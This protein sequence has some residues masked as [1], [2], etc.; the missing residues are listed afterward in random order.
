M[1][2]TI[3]WRTLWLSGLLLISAC[4]GG[5]DMLA[6]GG[7]TGSGMVNEGSISGF[8]S[9][10]VNDTR[11]ATEQ[12]EIRLNGEAGWSEQLKL[13]MHVIVEAT[14]DDN[15]AQRIIYRDLL[16]GPLEFIGPAS[17]RL[18]GH[19]VQITPDT[20]LHGVQQLSELQVGDTVRIS[21]PAASPDALF[22]TLLE[23]VPAG[24]VRIVGTVA[25]LD[26]ANHTFFIAGRRIDYSAVLTLAA[27]LYVGLPVEVVGLFGEG[28]LNARHIQSRRPE[29]LSEGKLA[30]IYGSVTRFDGPQDF[31]VQ[32]RPVRL[33]S[34]LTPDTT[35]GLSVGTRVKIRGIAD[36]QGVIEINEVTVH[37][38]RTAFSED[39]NL[40]IFRVSGP[41]SGIASDT[42]EVFGVAARF[43]ERSLFR[44]LSG[45][46][47]DY[48][49]ADIRSGD[50][51][52][53]GGRPEETT[54]FFAIMLNYEPF[55]PPQR[56]RL[57]G[58]AT[59]LDAS[60]RS[61][62]IFG[63]PVLSDARTR[64]YDASS[65]EFRLPPPGAPL[66]PPAD[67]ETD[68]AGFFA[69]LAAEPQ[70]LVYTAGTSAGDG[71]LAE[72][73]AV[74]PFERP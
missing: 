16:R 43:D 49:V 66:Q 59:D 65:M 17:L 33:G 10:I 20:R 46:H 67:T 18:L 54:P 37:D 34:D 39:P 35:S 28:K 72:S 4:S 52:S 14:A 32:Y 61:L 24:D 12:A 45:Q 21:G 29:P 58:P 55:A 9:I 1:K 27:Q 71:M 38:N 70:W 51:F 3:Y 53:M 50:Y 74:L 6:D 22:A 40:Q 41:V 36:A 13:G 31:E 11:Y 2:I 69:R 63:V 15:S 7:L 73:L 64:Y 68:A 44:D 60:N 57:Q 8:G 23:R 56:R 62:R 42:L 30:V 19:V 5:G 47:P 25:N 26:E 48:G